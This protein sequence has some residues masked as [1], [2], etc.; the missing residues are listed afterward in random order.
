MKEWSSRWLVGANGIYHGDIDTD[1]DQVGGYCYRVTSILR[2]RDRLVAGVG[3][4]VWEVPRDGSLWRQLHDETVTEVL[5]VA[6]MAGDPGVVSA[7]AYGVAT[8]QRDALGVVRWRSCSDKL[9]VNE[10]FSNAL[11]VDPADETRWLVGTEAGVLVA[12]SHG[13]I[14]HRTSLSDTPVRA[15]CYAMDAFWAGTDDAGVWRSSD[16]LRWDRAG[17]GLEQDCAFAIAESKGRLLVGTQAGVAYGDGRGPWRMTGPRV[18]MTA[19]AAHPQ[20]Q[21]IWMAGG[22]PGGLWYTADDGG[23]WQQINTLRIIETIL[24]PEVT[25]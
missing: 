12:E 4:G 22:N 20:Q 23:S 18:R 16:G 17:Q 8:G 14:W 7:S 13:D 19:L 3:S 9:R 11:L 15:L 2:E 10:R 5:D 25:E 1:W 24:A 6:A 21:E